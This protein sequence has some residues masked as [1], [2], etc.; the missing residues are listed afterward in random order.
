[1]AY[2]GAGWAAARLPWLRHGI[3]DRLEALD[4]LLGWL[5]LNGYGFHQGYFQRA[6]ENNPKLTHRGRRAFDEGL[7]RSLWFSECGDVDRI[8]STIGALPAR[9]HADLWSGVGLAATYA[10]VLPKADLIR[11]RS[12]AGIF[13]KDVSQ[14]CAFAAKARE[15]AGNIT[16]YTEIACGIF[17]GTSAREAAAKTD[18]ALAAERDSAAPDYLRW[19]ERIA[20]AVGEYREPYGRHSPVCS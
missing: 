19:R 7:G 5:V 2:I 1:M 4:R 6:S 20:N 8:G 3:E 12:T 13:A 14:G 15:R 16:E 9:R 17:C 18:R 10:G 11:L